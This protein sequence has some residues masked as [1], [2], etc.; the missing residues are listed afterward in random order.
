MHHNYCAGMLSVLCFV[1]YLKRTPLPLLDEATA[2]GFPGGRF[3]VSG[4]LP[5]ISL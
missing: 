1:Y 5:K 4:T 2:A 3:S